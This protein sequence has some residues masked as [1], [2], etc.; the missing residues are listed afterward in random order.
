MSVLL[1]FDG[2]RKVQ[3]IESESVVTGLI[4]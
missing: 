1:V 2:L 4:Q 3:A